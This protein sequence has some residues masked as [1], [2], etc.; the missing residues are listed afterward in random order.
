MDGGVTQNEA[1]PSL[2]A[3][4]P[5]YIKK[6]DKGDIDSPMTDPQKWLIDID[7]TAAALPCAQFRLIHLMSASRQEQVLHHS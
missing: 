1:S 4:P 6:V 7:S 2:G 3:E 5:L